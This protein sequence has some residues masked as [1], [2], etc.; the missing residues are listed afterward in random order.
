[1][2]ISASFLNSVT[3]L[4]TINISEPQFSNCGNNL[5][6]DVDDVLIR[7]L[8]LITLPPLSIGLSVYL[9]NGHVTIDSVPSWG[10]IDNVIN[11]DRNLTITTRAFFSS[12]RLSFDC[13]LDLAG[14]RAGCEQLIMS[15]SDMH[16]KLSLTMDKI[17]GLLS[18][19][20]VMALS[21][22]Y[23]VNGTLITGQQFNLSGDLPRTV[24]R[25][26]G[27]FVEDIANNAFVKASQ[28]TLISCNEPI[29]L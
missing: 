3:N 10:T 13:K 12:V 8:P 2:V 19:S 25:R 7:E 6:G 4:T 14:I 22:E 24:G 21:G 16:L 18:V 28:L 17:N 1:M 9:I 20:D 15:I 29:D 27:E 26:I 5:L 23:L 11:D